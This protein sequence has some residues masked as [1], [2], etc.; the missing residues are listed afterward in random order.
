[1]R[2]MIPGWANGRAD[3][4]GQAVL[5]F[6]GHT[7]LVFHVQLL[8]PFCLCCLRLVVPWW[9]QSSR[10]YRSLCTLALLEVR[11]V[12]RPL[13]SFSLFSFDNSTVT[14]HCCAPCYLVLAR[15]GIISLVLVLQLRALGSLEL[16]Y[17]EGWVN[18]PVRKGGKPWGDMDD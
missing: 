8:T 1:M 15:V 2:A 4:N 18:N 7:S 9:H 12:S 3:E 14:R 13:F 17:S 5:V 16:V 10:F 6:R 11:G